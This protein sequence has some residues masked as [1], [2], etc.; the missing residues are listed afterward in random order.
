M[1]IFLLLVM[2]FPFSLSTQEKEAVYV[3][4]TW[5]VYGFDALPLHIKLK[6]QMPVNSEIQISVS[7]TK[8]IDCGERSFNFTP[9]TG[10]PEK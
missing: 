7:I 5:N 1:K 4:G 3:V 8:R 2:M 6:N 10:V 9:A